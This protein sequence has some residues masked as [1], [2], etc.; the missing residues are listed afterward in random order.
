L[1][2]VCPADELANKGRLNTG[3]VC[4]LQRLKLSQTGQVRMSTGEHNKLIGSDPRPMRLAAGSHPH[5]AITRLCGLDHMNRMLGPTNYVAGESVLVNSR[6][7]ADDWRELSVLNDWVLDG[8][9][10]SND[11]PHFYMSTTGDARNDQLFNVAIQGA[12]QL[13]NGYGAPHHP[14]PRTTHDSSSTTRCCAQRTTR[15]AASPR[16]TTSGR[17]CPRWAPRTRCAPRTTSASRGAPTART[18]TWPA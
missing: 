8:V 18:A 2:G 5:A 12:C 15:A 1:A 11:N 7:P 13:N 9:V 4:F 17:P 16:A 6:N 14:Q 3:D 10:L